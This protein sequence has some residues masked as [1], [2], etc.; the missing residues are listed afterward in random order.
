MIKGCAFMQKQVYSNRVRIYSQNERIYK[1]S[2]DMNE[3][4]ENVL[5]GVHIIDCLQSE[6]SLNRITL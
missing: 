6:Y 1:P 4:C 2:S 3:L 5:P